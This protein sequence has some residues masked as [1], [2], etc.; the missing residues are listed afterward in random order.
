MDSWLSYPDVISTEPSHLVS[1][2]DLGLAIRRLKPKEL[3]MT[4]AGP[5]DASLLNHLSRTGSIRTLEMAGADL[6]DDSI[7]YIAK[8]EGLEQLQ[9]SDT[10]ITGKALEALGKCPSLKVLCIGGT[11]ITKTEAQEFAK[12]HPG[13]RV[14]R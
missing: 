1:S 3:I 9:V 14:V 6:N 4:G 12:R 11:E 10:G 2:A 8:M 13:I 5:L 7:V